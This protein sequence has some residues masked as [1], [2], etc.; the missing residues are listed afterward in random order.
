[1]EGQP[2]PSVRGRF[3]F[4][5]ACARARL[6]T[7]FNQIMFTSQQFNLARV[8]HGRYLQPE[9]WVLDQG[10]RQFVSHCSDNNVLGGPRKE[11]ALGL[12]QDK[13]K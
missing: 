5:S 13:R 2:D 11:E 8:N 6:L 9:T 7:T 3:P 12:N 4:T 10:L 1:M